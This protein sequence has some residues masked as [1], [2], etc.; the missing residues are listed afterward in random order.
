MPEY[1]QMKEDDVAELA[2]MFRAV[3]DALRSIRTTCDEEK[4]R[5]I[6]EEALAEIEKSAKLRLTSNTH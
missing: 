6:A 4:C 2:K 3:V 5:T 1:E